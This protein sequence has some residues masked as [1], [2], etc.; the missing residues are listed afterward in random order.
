MKDEKLMK[1]E[2]EKERT[3]ETKKRVKNKYKCRNWD[4]RKKTEETGGGGS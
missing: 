1:R 3:E 4:G 2:S